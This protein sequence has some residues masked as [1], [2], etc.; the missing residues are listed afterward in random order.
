VGRNA[1]IGAN[2]FVM[3]RD[4]PADCTAVGNPARIVKQDGRRVER[5]L[6]LTVLPE[7]S[8][9]RPEAPPAGALP[10]RPEP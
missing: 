7:R 1:R 8:I 5:E 2:S 3:M 4:V 9:P 6:P 10:A